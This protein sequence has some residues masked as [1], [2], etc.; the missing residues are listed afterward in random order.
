LEEQSRQTAEW[1]RLLEAELEDKEATKKE[2]QEL[3]QQLREKDAQIEHLRYALDQNPDACDD[4]HI[5]VPQTMEEAVLALQK[6]SHESYLVVLPSAIGAARDS[7]FCNPQRV[8]KALLGLS[9]IARLYHAGI[10]SKHPTDL[11]RTMCQMDIASDISPTARGKY[12]RHYEFL[13]GT[14]KVTAGPHLGTG[15]GG[16][17]DCFRA[18]WHVDETARRYVLC[19]VGEHL[20]DDTKN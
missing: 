18:Y 9:H 4:L 10:E 1:T 2:N 11:L 7:S 16:P 20:P 19:H 15:R 13:Y 8:F 14:A 5:E 17:N 6:L 3:H 12:G